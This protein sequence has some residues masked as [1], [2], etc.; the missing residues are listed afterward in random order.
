M[1]Q[2]QYPKI[3]FGIIVLNGEPFTRYCL[4]SIYPF[5]H[6]I[7]VVEGGHENAV[8]VCTPDGHSID[9]TLEALRRFKQEE[10]PENKLQIITRDGFW[11]MKDE[12]GRYRTHQSRAYAE[13][14]TGDYLWQVDIDEFY[15][16]DDMRYVIN[17]LK[18]DPAI[19]AVSFQTQTFWGDVA[20]TVD[21]WPLRRGLN[22]HHRL[23]KWGNG[24]RYVTHE[25]PTVYDANGI[26]MHSLNWVKGETLAKRGI[27]L[28]HYAF[29]FPWEVYQKVS[30]YQSEKKTTY[31]KITEWSKN[32]YFRLGNPYRVYSY[33]QSPSWLERFYGK[34]PKQIVQM[35][36]DVHSGKI[37]AELRQTDDIER[38]LNSRGY[39]IRRTWLKYLDFINRFLIG[40]V[41]LSIKLFLKIK[42]CIPPL[43]KFSFTQAFYKIVR[44]GR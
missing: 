2:P 36:E 41:D 15:H 40:I 20:Y 38:L 24:F 14:A 37:K 35:M 6:E 13:K 21:S 28:Y 34:H 7:I 8:A 18:Q 44:R 19:T 25:P 3:T 4:K 43:R 17:L 42:N 10:D 26:D 27:Y 29:L 23:F 30:V 11:P 31:A 12:L 22:I 5:A 33:Y 32:N 39:I 16:E 9:G 1:N